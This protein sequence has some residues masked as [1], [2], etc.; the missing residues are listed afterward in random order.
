MAWGHVLDALLNGSPWAIVIVLGL[1]GWKLRCEYVSVID[2]KSAENREKD[3]KIQALNSELKNTVREMS[4]HVETV[5]QH[6]HEEALRIQ[7]EGHAEIRKMQQEFQTTMAQ[8]D[9]TLQGL[10]SAIQSSN[11]GR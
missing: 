3:N 1:L 8:L 4:E 10:C 9:G 11:R 2:E 7:N 5:M 6:A